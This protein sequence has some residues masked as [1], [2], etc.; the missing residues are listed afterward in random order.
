MKL[1]EPDRV[2]VERQVIN[3]PL[4]QS[5]IGKVDSK[6]IEVIASGKALIE[7]MNHSGASLA[8]GKKALLLAEYRGDFLKPCPGTRGYVCCNY[9]I[10]NF[11]TNC[12]MDCSYC[13]LQGYLNAPV[14]VVHAN[15]DAMFRALEREF[16]S[17]PNRLFRVGTGEFTD[18][19][20][21][22]HLIDFTKL[23]VPFFARQLP[24]QAGRNAFLELKT[25]TDNIGNLAGLPHG[26]RTIV[27]WSLNPDPIIASE[28]E[29]TASLAE[30]L[31][32]AKI[33]QDA[34]YLLA[35]H[36]D[37]IICY[38]G[39][40][41]GY[42]NVVEQLFAR[43]RPERIV[44]ISLGCLRFPP[45]LKRVVQ[46]RF[47]HSRITYEEFVQ[48]SPARAGGDGKLR[49]FR[50][51]RVKMYSEVIQHIRRC[52]PQVRLYLCMES[53]RVWQQT[54]GSRPQSNAQVDADLSAQ[55]GLGQSCLLAQ[56][57]LERRQT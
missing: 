49:Y 3:S 45:G 32:A 35:F 10:L 43:I 38:D 15:V 39:W 51:L 31:Q 1:Y 41:D 40:E 36:F 25:K 53:R 46:E 24:V 30:R 23:A 34:G 52:A 14:L 37:P 48:G 17:Q 33:C 44:W 29:K 18:S 5:V 55:A 19:L 21:L 12:P 9:Q 26:G 13:I 56:A 54:L 27:A 20:A 28:E 4:A 11:A 57:C 42:R 7:E 16:R 2:Y 47:P 6:R 50:P 22:D 8:G